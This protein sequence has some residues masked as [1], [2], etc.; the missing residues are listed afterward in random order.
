[1][2]HMEVRVYTK[3]GK[4]ESSRV[5]KLDESDFADVL[6]SKLKDEEELEKFSVERVSF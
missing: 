2:D 1:M 3:E 4:Y 6:K 5:I